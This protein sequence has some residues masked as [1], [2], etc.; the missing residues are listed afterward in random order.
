MDCPYFH[1]KEVITMRMPVNKPKKPTGRR[2]KNKIFS[3]KP[4]NPRGSVKRFKSRVLPKL[5]AHANVDDFT[6]EE[7]RDLKAYIKSQ[8]KEIRKMLEDQEAQ[9]T[10]TGSNAR[11][12]RLADRPLND[13]P[14]D[15]FS[16]YMRQQQFYIDIQTDFDFIKES[17]VDHDLEVLMEDADKW[18]ILRRLA[19]V[20]H[21]LNI[22]RAYA[23]DVLHEI[24]NLIGTYNQSLTYGELADILVEDYLDQKDHPHDDS[25]MPT[26]GSKEMLRLWHTQLNPFDSDDL[27][28][29]NK[30]FHGRNR[31]EQDQERQYR[32][33]RQDMSAYEPV[34][35]S[36]VDLD[37]YIDEW[38]G[39]YEY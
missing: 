10:P 8:Q 16:E 20:D 1:R 11:I 27:L 15:L 24:E 2:G 26:S 25:F 17:K 6:L 34:W 22:D 12:N 35:S 3:G 33:L 29:A 5:M 32:R 38:G 30:G 9:N 31:A 7:R 37:D 14:A 18:N 19:S 21:R 28:F 36:Q 13:D 39:I 4:Y 23:S